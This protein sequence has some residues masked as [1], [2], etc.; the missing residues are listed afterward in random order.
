[1]C[2]NVKEHSIFYV[3]TVVTVSLL[4]PPGVVDGKGDTAGWIGDICHINSLLKGVFVHEKN[5]DTVELGEVW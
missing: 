1:V 3:G 4:T 2:D 5:V